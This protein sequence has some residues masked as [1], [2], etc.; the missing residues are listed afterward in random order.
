ME[1]GPKRQVETRPIKGTRRRGATRAEDAA[2]A[3]ELLASE[4]DRAE[5]LMIVD[6]LRNDLARVSEIGSVKVPQLCALESF[7]AVH[8]LV[9]VVTS[10]LRPDCGQP[11]ESISACNRPLAEP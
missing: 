9:S 1:V 11:L 7:A 10:R 4:K 2:L 8:H 3:E 6:L 5:N